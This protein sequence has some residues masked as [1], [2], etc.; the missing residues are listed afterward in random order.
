MQNAEGIT[1]VLMEMLTALDPNNPQVELLNS[2]YT[3]TS[4]FPFF[5]LFKVCI[6]ADSFDIICCSGA[7]GSD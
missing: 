4:F 1:D 2:T 3:V 6:Y 7:R 5:P